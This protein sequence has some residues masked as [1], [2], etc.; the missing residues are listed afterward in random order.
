[1]QEPSK[2]LHVKQAASAWSSTVISTMI[3][4]MVSTPPAWAVS[5]QVSMNQRL[6]SFVCTHTEKEVRKV[7]LPI[8]KLAL[9]SFV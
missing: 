3:L 7:H 2:V 4:I 6:L 5:V 1:M 9:W 8:L